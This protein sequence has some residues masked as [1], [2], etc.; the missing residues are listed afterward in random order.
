MR[1]TMFALSVG[2]AASASAQIT[3]LD[4]TN[5]ERSAT[6]ALPE[7]EAS[8]ASGIT[9]NPETGNLFV[10]GDEGEWIAEVTTQG[11]LVSSMTLTSFDDPEGMTYIGGGMVVVAEER[12][13]DLHLIH[14]AAGGSIDRSETQAISLGENVGNV[15]LE[16]ISYESLTGK[17]FLVKEKTPQA[18]YEATLDFDA[19]QGSVSS[20]FDPIGLGVS[21]LSDI[22]VLSAVPS[23][24]GTEDQDNLLIFSQESALLMEVARD[25]TVRSTFDFSAIAGDAEGVTVGTDGTIYVCGETPSLYV[26]TPDSCRADIDGND[27]LDLFDFLEFVNLFNAG[28]L[29]ADFDGNELLDLFDFLEFVNQFNAGC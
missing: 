17:Y 10:I 19:G 24:I 25:G 28:D 12:E 8:E 6:Y 1:I 2:L 13:Q 7:V 4:L 9:F 18:V 26:L 3:S 11:V 14:Y 29:A 21:D 16:G 23:L 20:L 15:G 27:L 22:Q 5:D